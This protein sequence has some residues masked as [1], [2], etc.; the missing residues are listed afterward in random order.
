MTEVQYRTLIDGI[1]EVQEQDFEEYC[2]TNPFKVHNSDGFEYK[3]GIEG[4]VT[5]EP[6]LIALVRELAWDLR[7]LQ[8]TRGYS[9]K[10]WPAQTKSKMEE[11]LSKFIQVIK[12]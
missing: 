10:R 2:I 1:L 4:I 9:T 6:N 7:W 5:K 3:F 8:E 12:K 11:E